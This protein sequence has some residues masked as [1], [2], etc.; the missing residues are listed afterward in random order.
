M[1]KNKKKLL[2]LVGLAL[3]ALMTTIAYLLPADGA[4]AEGASDSHTDTI[5][6]TVYNPDQHPS[7]KFT[8]PEDGHAQ[9]NPLFRFNFDYTNASAVKLTLKYYATNED[10]GEVELVQ[11]PVEDFVPSDLDPTFNITSGSQEYDFNLATCK[12]GF[13]GEEYN[14]PDCRAVR[15]GGL[16][17]ASLF[18][19]VNDETLGYNHYFLHIEA[20]SP[21]G[22]DEDDIEFYYVPVTV[23]QIG[24]E[25]GTNN[26]IATVTYDD[27][28]ARIE[29][30]PIDKDGNPLFDEPVVVTVEPD[31]TG[32]F[33]AGSQTITFPFT[34]YGLPSGDYDIEVTAY[35]GKE[36]TVTPGEI[37]P[38]TGLP[39]DDIITYDTKFEAPAIRYVLNYVQPPAPDVPN[40]GHFLGGLSLAS[41]DIIITSAIAFTGC[42][43][44]AFAFIGHKKKDYRKNI[45][46]RR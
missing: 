24:S 3:V 23:T 2:G 28:V 34:S 25:D 5:R 12:V 31:E 15:T 44:L 33:K 27:D 41:S 14:I 1:Q 7:I 19:P 35:N 22:Y 29:I 38:E 46:G 37:D 32:K 36:P 26:P 11:I 39:G 42:A 9:A 17:S 20:D 45:R 16:M 4:F 40:T 6:V 10:T 8:S 13:N 18:A 30:M 43:I 21:V